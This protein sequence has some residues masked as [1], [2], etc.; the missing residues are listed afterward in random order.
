MRFRSPFAFHLW[1]GPGSLSL[2]AMIVSVALSAS[3]PNA[4]AASRR[5]LRLEGVPAPIGAQ[6]RRAFPGAFE[7]GASLAQVDEIV[8]YLMKTGSFSYVEAAERGSEAVVQAIL[9]RRIAEIRV[10]GN[11]R[12]SESEVARRLGVATG[13]PFERKNLQ[14]A[15]DLITR[16]YGEAGF[17]N[18]KAEI[19]FET[20]NEKDVNV[21][22]AISEGLP[23]TIVDT[24]FDVAN[25]ALKKRLKAMAK[26]ILGDP[27]SNEAVFG[28]QTQANEWF[29]QNR[30]LTAKLSNPSVSLDEKREKA[31]LTWQLESPYRWEFIF[32]GNQAYGDGALIRSMELDKLVGVT[33][34]PAVD[35]A[36]RVRKRYYAGGYAHASVEYSEKSFEDI[37]K[38][39]ISF[40]IV[41]GPRVRIRRIEV[42]GSISRSEKYYSDFIHANSSELV[43]S[44]F[45][46]RADIEKGAKNLVIELQNQGFLKAKIP[47]SRVEFDRSKEY[48]TVVIQLDEGPLTQLRQIK[49]EGVT[50][51]SK[52]QLAD[53]MSIKANSPLSLVSLEES[54]VQLKEFYRSR[55][56]LEMKVLNENEP[57]TLVVYNETNTQA[58]VEIRVSEGPKITV[59][60][61]VIQG[62]TFT[63][64]YV[65]ARVLAFKP[66]DVLT[67]E[68]IDESTVRLQKMAL[69]S[70]VA[71]RT[72]EDGQNVSDRTVIVEVA[73]RDPGIFSS[74]VGITN[75]RLLTYR[76]FAG[77]SY[78]NIGGTGRAVSAR[79][80]LQYSNLVNFPEN[81]ITL[82]YVE[83]YILNG[84]NRGRAS[85][86]R[87]QEFWLTEPVKGVQIRDSNAIELLIERDVSRHLKFTFAAWRFSNDK[88]F[89][90]TDNSIVQT[91]NVGKIGPLIEYDRRD[92]TFNPSRGSYSFANFEF[93]DPKL[94]SSDDDVQLIQF[95][96]INGGTTVYLP[97]AGSSKFVWANAV[98]SGYVANIS[99]DARSGVPAVEAFFLGGRSTIRGYDPVDQAQLIPNYDQLKIPDNG[100]G[101]TQFNVKNDSWYYLVK[102]EIRFPI[103][104]AFGGAIFYDGG[105]VFV[106]DGLID[107]QVVPIDIQEPYRHAAGFAIRVATP[108]GPLNLEVGFKLNRRTLKNGTLE[109][110]LAYHFSVGAF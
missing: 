33:A 4:V 77:F 36:E 110:P 99:R 19:S 65:V 106:N 21:V 67:P 44:N 59:G 30:Y 28:F 82:G 86:T 41:E 60:S 26:P 108:V 57:E 94:G 24:T 46:N 97:I 74:G 22:V 63:K 64:E 102:S 14:S 68:R 32:E 18:A 35:L 78:R 81:K 40:Q 3:T 39:Q 62:N 58:N 109:S 54:L 34:S 8:R 53:A 12:F 89:R 47:S 103:Y 16:E 25:P 95:M 70:S 79:A 83:P 13:D 49:F 45:Y 100:K 71:I 11:R 20:P 9:Q 48:A 7:G 96:K 85:L 93:A 6:V 66:G 87:K 17:V 92:D 101:L 52:S 80:D 29:Q 55:G 43:S 42:Q 104:G 73:E 56:F 15:A 37:F 38:K 27:L 61:I 91:Q 84:P 23:C 69:F 10:T 88:I 1:P 107:R 51:F 50:A 90:Q 72:L 98:R 76:G 31:K 5:T 2:W 75:E 105:A